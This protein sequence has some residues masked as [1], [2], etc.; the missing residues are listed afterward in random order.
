MRKYYTIASIFLLI[1]SI[2]FFGYFYFQYNL[3][4]RYWG[5]DWLGTLWLSPENENVEEVFESRYE[6]VALGS[7]RLEADFYILTVY[8]DNV[9]K[10]ILMNPKTSIIYLVNDKGDILPTNIQTLLLKV[11]KDIE[12]N[13]YR[14]IYSSNW[15]LDTAFI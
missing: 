5:N 6:K 15:Y 8:K 12:L 9:K 7:V 3:S 4:L 1:F 14:R 10:D 13:Y 11:G 2:I